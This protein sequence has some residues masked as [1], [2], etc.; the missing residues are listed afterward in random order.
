MSVSTCPLQPNV[1]SVGSTS[2]LRIEVEQV[3]N[4]NNDRWSGEFTAQCKHLF[5]IFYFFVVIVI[6]IIIITVIILHTLSSDI[7]SNP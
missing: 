7:Q 3:D 4:E 6:I 1:A 5:F 2:L